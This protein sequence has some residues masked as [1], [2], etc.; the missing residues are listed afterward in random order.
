MVVNIDI[1]QCNESELTTIVDYKIEPA[2]EYIL[3]TGVK[4]LIVTKGENGVAAFYKEGNIIKQIFLEAEKVITKNKIGCGDI[5]GAVF[6][7]SYLRGGNLEESLKNANKAAAITAANSTGEISF[8]I[9]NG[10]V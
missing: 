8:M 6:F 9:K 2:V 7:Y 3:N 4:I 10:L 1:L 5:F